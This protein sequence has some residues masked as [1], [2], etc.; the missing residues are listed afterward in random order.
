MTQ[1]SDP[2]LSLILPQSSF[3]HNE[4]EPP[5][6]L[7]EKSQQTIV[8]YRDRAISTAVDAATSGNVSA[9]THQLHPPSRNVFPELP[10][11]VSRD[12]QTFD[13]GEFV[14]STKAS[15][16]VSRSPDRARQKRLFV[17][18]RGT[19]AFSFE[20]ERHGGERS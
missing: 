17:E 12:V 8:K 4:H 16:E 10:P 3:L 11:L 9:R 5:F 6:A 18:D 1:P 19:D 7:S 13:L 2:N 20:D 15:A 14:R